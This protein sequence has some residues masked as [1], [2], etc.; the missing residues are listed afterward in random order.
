MLSLLLLRRLLT[1]C[2]CSSMSPFPWA[3]AL[4]KLPQY[5]S[6]PRGAVLQ[7]QAAPAW[8]PQTGSQALPA[9]LLQRGLLSPQV[10]AGACSSVGSPWG[11]RLLRASTCSGV[12]SLPRATGGDLLH[13][14]PPWTA[15]AQ[16]ASP[17]SSLRVAREGSLL[18]C[19]EHLLP[20]RASSLT[21]VSAELF[22]TLSHSSLL[23]A[24]SLQVFFPV[25]LN[26]YH[27]GTT[28]VTDWLG[29]GQRWVRLRA[30]WHWLYQAR[31][32]L[33][34]EATPIVPLLPKPCHANP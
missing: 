25:L 19:L 18:R 6:F 26:C 17:W 34:T 3:A 5:G 8:V 4:H 9:N 16:P 28:T 31:G 20:P 23:T 14:G 33:L 12:G 21:L 27:R 11:H 2:P 10:L 7:E 32:K 30:G 29:L 24:I 22:L 1:F 15:G 13:C